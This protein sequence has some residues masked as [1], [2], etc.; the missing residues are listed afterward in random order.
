MASPSLVIRRLKV[1]GELC[2]DLRFER[3]LNVVHAYVSHGDPKSTNTCGK[4]ALVELIQFGLG[5]RVESKA[6]FHLAPIAHRLDRLWLE[7]EANG[8][9]VLIERSLRETH[10][11]VRVRWEEYRSGI[12][13]SPADSFAVEEISALLLDVLRIP[14]VSVKTADGGM[15]PLTLPLLMR[16]FVLHQEDSFGA[17]LDK[18]LPERRRADVIGFLSRI[19]PVEAFD[20]EPKLAEV[21]TQAQKL[22][23][24][25]EA[26]T[27]FLREHGIVRVV[28]AE[29]RLKEAEQAVAEAKSLQRVVQDEMRSRAGSTV[30]KGDGRIDRLRAELLAA[31]EEAGRVSHSVA[32]LR[33]E[34]RRLDEVRASL[35]VDG[36]RVRRLK[37]SSDLLGTI[38]FRMCPRC[39]LEITPEMRG[40]ED[41]SRC[42]LCN[43][44]IRR[45]SDA[46][47]RAAPSPDDIEAQIAETEEILE[48]VRAEQTQAET[49]LAA[50]SER[51]AR[52]GA[53]LD[54]QTA[55]YVA[56]A[57]DRLL[58][59]AQFLSEREADLNRVRALLGQAQA[60]E[61][62]AENLQAL[63]GRQEILES[64]LRQ[65]KKASQ[66]RL[67]LLRQSY[68]AVLMAVSFPN[69]RECSIAPDTLMPYINGTLYVHV[70]TAMKGLATVAY[71]LALLDLAETADTFLPKFL[72]IDSPAHGDLNDENHDRLLRYLA[73]KQ[74]EGKGEPDWQIILTTR[75]LITE[76]EPFVMARVSAPDDMLLELRQG[77]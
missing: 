22:T 39:M 72:V 26:V 36:Q 35:R 69:V 58:M 28:D 48:A 14:K 49:L 47:P 25:V 19:T 21:Q 42:S 9:V 45:V 16:A 27:E 77:R 8:V 41:H 10:S 73:D 61:Q 34:A 57:V 64:Q 62:M 11:A 52:L 75:R 18:V 55:A 31:K 66:A 76:L 2:C 53:E 32:S 3:G 67:E 50:A 33:E 65:A 29:S 46:A 4:T 51:A 17:I 60:L 1:D 54:D 71:H 5:R 12:E 70:G 40:R 23:A 74:N 6:K 15:Q 68:Q 38:D 43:R 59:Q 63:L 24:R 7:I 56:P 20:L 37:A 44:P 13:A 30:A